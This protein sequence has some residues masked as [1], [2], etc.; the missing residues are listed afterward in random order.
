MLELWVGEEVSL[1]LDFHYG[2][3]EAEW[4][5]PVDEIFPESGLAWNVKIMRHL[6][7][8]R[9]QIYWNA[10]PFRLVNGYRPFGGQ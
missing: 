9:L 5:F 6:T 8:S 10:R 2:I 3:E 7:V 1:F 4:N